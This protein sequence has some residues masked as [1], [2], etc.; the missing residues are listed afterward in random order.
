M[1]SAVTV[2][3][4]VI[5]VSLGAWLLLSHQLTTVIDE[6][7]NKQVGFATRLASSGTKVPAPNTGPDT[8]LFQTIFPDGSVLT[9]VGQQKIPVS[10]KD[11]EVARNELSE[12]RQD[13]SINGANY[14]VLT[15]WVH[16]KQTGPQG[17]AVQIAVGLSE[18]QGTLAGFGILLAI[19]GGVGVIAAGAL[20]FVVTRSGLRPVRRVVAAAEHVASSKDLDALVPVE[21]RDPN[22]VARVAD[23]M[24]A[25]L[26]ALKASR[27]AQ[28]QLVEN[29]GHELATPLTSLRTNI[30]LLL[31]T[32]N[33]PERQLSAQDRTRLLLDIQA[34]MNEL[35]DLISEVVELARD[36]Q[37]GEETIELNLADVVGSAVTRARARTPHITFSLTQESIMLRGMPGGLERAVLNLL[38]NAAKWSPADQPVEVTVQRKN[39]FAQV[40][41]ADRGPGV[42]EWERDKVFERFHRT[43]EARSMPGSG[44]GLAI[45]RQIVQA[46]GG[47][48]WLTGRTGGGTE[49]WIQLPITARETL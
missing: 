31:R 24:N 43:S 28:R 16:T 9:P 17:H 37:S 26:G 34:Q 15:K 2:A 5:G 46:H 3:V 7:L 10:K 48:A 11:Q 47:Q 42:A 38:D 30:E 22:E 41:V 40:M 49:A 12:V 21:A 18:M 32:E 8:P 35:N 4:A 44:L 13:I 36:P 1:L 23:S 20:G 6:R 25:M 45:V 14:R 29:A 39:N 19:T 27:D 33:Y